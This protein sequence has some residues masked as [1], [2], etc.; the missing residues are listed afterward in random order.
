MAHDLEYFDKFFADPASMKAREFYHY[1]HEWLAYLKEH[2]GEFNYLE[3]EDW[4]ER[5]DRVLAVLT[6]QEDLREEF[7]EIEE[8]LE[9]I[10]EYED[11]EKI[12]IYE[13]W[14]AFLRKHQ[15]N[16][17]IPDEALADTEARTQSIIIS[18]L[19]CEILEERLKRSRAK[20]QKSLASMDD[21]LAD[22]Y[23]RTGKRMVL[24]SLAYEFGKRL[25]GN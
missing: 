10:E 7:E 19:D 4:K 16:Y 24:T 2:E 1:V 8:R 22:F 20:Y 5:K 6:E 14:L 15:A 13:E 17:D 3:D 21:A 25:K 9:F 12:V 11:A 23:V 18:I